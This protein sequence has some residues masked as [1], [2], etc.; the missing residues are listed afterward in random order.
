MGNVKYKEA[1]GSFVK[2]AA[3]GGVNFTGRKSVGMENA[4]G[5]F[6]Y[7]RLDKLIPFRNQAR[8]VFDSEEIELLADSIKNYG[9]RQPLSVMAS[10]MQI[11]CFE[12]ISGER[13]AKA[14]R[15]AGLEKV[16]CLIIKDN[17]EADVAAVIENIHRSDLHPVELA[18]AYNSL[19]TN[20]TFS[21]AAELY[22]ALG[23]NKSS[24]YEILQI[25]NLPEDVQQAL[26][27]NNVRS[28]DKIRSLMKSK[29]PSELI[30]SM[31]SHEHSK[32]INKIS[33]RSSSIMRINFVDGDFSVQNSAIK[34]LS[35]EEREKLK[36]VL[37]D[38]AEIL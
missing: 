2:M 27:D 38:I 36:Q 34:K 1:S 32:N 3:P 26:L 22:E 30:N 18:R 5:E 13:R 35:L 25:L 4:F 9:V 19:L 6:F 17:G 11:G 7:I 10:L 23:L 24:A 14:A 16:P 15:I 37:L 20:G 21:S 8:E 29:N 33:S 31:V 12:I 28:R